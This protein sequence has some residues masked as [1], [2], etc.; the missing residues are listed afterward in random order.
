M[1]LETLKNYKIV[2]AAVPAG[3]SEAAMFLKQS[4]ESVLETEIPCEEDLDAVGDEFEILIGNTSRCS[5]HEDL[6]SYRICSDEKRIFLLCGGAYSAMHGA[7]E[8]KQL[9]LTDVDLTGYN[10]KKV[11]L[12]LTPIHRD[13]DDSIRVMTS[14]ILAH[15]WLVGDRPSVAQ[16]A[17]IYAAVLKKYAPDL[18]GVQETDLPWTKHLPYYLDLLSERYGLNYQW[19]Q[20]WVDGVPNMSSILYNKDRFTSKNYSVREFSYMVHR[21]YKIRVLTW[22]VLTDQRIKKDVAVINTHWSVKKDH[23]PYELIEETALI[24]ELEETYGNLPIFCTGDFNSHINFASEKFIEIAG[25]FD[26]KELAEENN[27][28]VNRLSGIAEGIY[29]DHIY[30]NRKFNILRYETVENE[31]Y[32]VLSDHLPHCA[33]IL[34]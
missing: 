30:C 1:N 33:D 18:V 10:K 16:R 19:N 5:L 3:L 9:L 22:I 28:L 31:H 23:N 6:M 32:Y 15:C 12:P 21:D 24:R 34:L 4:L 8:L 20:Y 29:I 17:E 26:S 7:E 27:T 14:N 13:C 25:V 11:L 2:Y